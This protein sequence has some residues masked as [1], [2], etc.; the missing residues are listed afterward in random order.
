M[1]RVVKIL[2]FM[3]AR[4]NGMAVSD[5]KCDP[6][7]GANV[8]AE[9]TA[10]AGDDSHPLPGDYAVVSDASG[11][12]RQ[13]TVGYFDPLNAPKAGPG[14]KRIYARN[15]SGSA[16]VELWLKNSGEVII[17]NGSGTFT[18]EPGGTFNINGLKI[19]PDGNATTASGVS[20]SGHTHNQGADSDGN[21]Q[22]TTNPPNAG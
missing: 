9:H 1:G 21:S 20:L 15:A 2:S 7:G 22:A 12:G 14:E 18:L 5:V 16:V 8:T 17:S 13:S 4:R 10:P 19:T 6:G 3:R 11:T